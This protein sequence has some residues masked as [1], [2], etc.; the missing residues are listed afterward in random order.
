MISRKPH[1][2][3]GNAATPLRVAVFYF[4]GPE[5]MEPLDEAGVYIA[6]LYDDNFGA[7][8]LEFED[9]P[10]F[11]VLASSLPGDVGLQERA[12]GLTLWFLRE[13]KPVSFM[14]VGPDLRNNRVLPF[15]KTEARTL[16]Y[17][18]DALNEPQG[19][20]YLVGPQPQRDS[21]G[22]PEWFQE[23]NQ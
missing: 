3:E 18:M 22:H 19:S 10:L 2:N 8:H 5:L 4:C 14:L 13:R 9:M 15:L 1:G 12:T 6:C 20:T 23:R 17:R 7:E 21:S 16:G 11:N